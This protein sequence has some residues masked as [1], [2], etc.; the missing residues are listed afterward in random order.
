MVDQSSGGNALYVVGI[1]SI[2]CGLG[3][4]FLKDGTGTKQELSSFYGA[5]PAKP[6]PLPAI[7]RPH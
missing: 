1:I 6:V 2:L 5:S 7:I 4:F 3:V